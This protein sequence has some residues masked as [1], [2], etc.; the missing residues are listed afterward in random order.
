MTEIEDRL[1]ELDRK[2]LNLVDVCSA[3]AD[4][5]LRL[6]FIFDEMNRVGVLPPLPWELATSLVELHHAMQAEKAGDQD[7]CGVPIVERI[8]TL[9]HEILSLRNEYQKSLKETPPSEEQPTG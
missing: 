8:S 4:D 1:N 6:C 2:V 5:T 3:V 7:G 9:K